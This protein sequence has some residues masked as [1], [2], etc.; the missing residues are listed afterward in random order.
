MIRR[1]PRSTLFP[2]TTLFRSVENL[3][4]GKLIVV[5]NHQAVGAIE[6]RR[7][8]VG[9][10]IEVV[11][12]LSQTVQLVS[13]DGPG[14]IVNRLGP[15]VAP[16]EIETSA[17]L[18]AQGRLKR[19]IDRVS[20]LAL[21]ETP[22]V[23]EPQKLNRDSRVDV[24]RRAA[25][26]GDTSVGTLGYEL[27]ASRHVHTRTDF[28]RDNAGPGSSA[29]LA[30]VERT[31]GA[32]QTVTMRAYVTQLKVPSLEK[33]PL[34]AEVPL[35]GVGRPEVP[36]REEE[37]PGER[38]AA[39][40]LEDGSAGRLIEPDQLRH[41]LVSR[42]REIRGRADARERVGEGDAQGRCANGLG[43]GQAA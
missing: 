17:E 40:T 22:R 6:V 14:A 32:D 3:G 11:A 35:L 16:L 41:N 29:N 28:R 18:V 9:P 37:E 4:E 19:V 39:G 2:Y 25:S 43:E 36:H 30:G 5:A 8:A 31:P 13:E 21:E 34:D 15:G 33:L 20:F 42:E 26:N 38:A 10:A 7:T 24:V 1:P 23:G 27:C 12:V